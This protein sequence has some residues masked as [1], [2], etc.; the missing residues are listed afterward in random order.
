M[1]YK[2]N[3]TMFNKLTYL[4]IALL[5]TPDLFASKDNN[6]I[7][8]KIIEKENGKALPYATISVQDD[9]LKI[10][11]GTTSDEE[12]KFTITNVE[13]DSF[14]VKISFIG[15]KDTILN[16]NVDDLTDNNLGIIALAPDA[17]TLKAAVITEKIPVIEHKV[18]KI[19]MNVS[20]AVSTQGSSTLD[21]LKKAPG[22]SVDP[23]GNILLNG[24][25]VQIW[26][27]NRPSNLTGTDLEALLSGTD[28]S[29]IDK[30]EII[31]HPSAKYDAEGSSGI[32]NIKTKKNFAKGLSGSLRA[33]YGISPFESELYNSASSS[34]NLAYRGNKSNTAITYSPKYDES[35]DKF[36][37]ETNLGESQLLKGETLYKSISK[38]FNFRVS[39]DYYINKQNIMGVIISGLNRKNDDNTDN[40]ITGTK[41][42][43]NGNLIKTNNT[44]I[45]GNSN[46]NNIYTNLNYTHIFKDNHEVT[47]NAD[48][49][50]YDIGSDSHQENNYFN[51]I[52]GIDDPSDIF[53]SNS[54]QY[55]NIVSAKLDY[56]QLV[57]NKIM[58]EAGG[59][60]AQSQTDNNLKR[61]DF[62][63]NVWVKNNILSS[64]FNYKE[65][66]VASY[67]SAGMQFGPKLS[68]KAGIRAEYT[69]SN[70]NWISADTTT[71]KKYLNLFPTLYFGFNPNKNI[72]IATTY[73]LRIQ[74][75]NFS[76]LNPFRVYVDANTS[77]EGNPNLLPQYTHQ[78][79]LSLIYKQ[80]FSLGFHGQ[81]N[82]KTIIQ[83]TK[84]NPV[85]GEKLLIWENFGNLNLYGGFFNI[86][87]LPVTKWLTINSGFFAAQ[88]KSKTE[89]YEKKSLFSSIN[90]NAALSLPSDTKIELSGFF[91]SGVPYGY[92]KV[93]P[94]GDI[95]LGIKKGVLDNRG[96]LIL[97]C[98]DLLLTQNSRAS[99]LTDMI[100]NYR[101]KSQWKSREISISFLYRFGNGSATK[102]RK[103]GESEEAKRAESDN[104][105]K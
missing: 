9:N 88:I 26:I 70:G 101:F 95:S 49:G 32:V 24:N 39:H 60:W 85:T 81:F 78:A 20:E 58:L 48:Y 67:V 44:T 46:F 62:I 8:G 76:Q 11:G 36:A 84:F 63:D 45:A 5:I 43:K 89:G 64:K 57:L 73:N 50:Y 93:K 92:F 77:V 7:K 99:L 16:V 72:T 61:E 86:T 3:S 23:S 100:E 103:V 65:N 40:D 18:D 31:A 102:S 104:A 96:T 30:I 4:L 54:K 21:I 90:I 94:Q 82:T 15:F 33:T 69:I 10:L 37:S 17:S 42:Y 27:D 66:I 52:E 34:I 79:S 14:M 56:E 91:Q 1:Y 28:G 87:E 74:R 80:N 97:N 47:L 6:I 83:N 53:N 71:Q 13:I 2:T 41:L 35:F 38:R 29:T 25:I 98:S 12:G 59:K 68:A 22:I 75:P 19:V 105:K 55:L 51:V